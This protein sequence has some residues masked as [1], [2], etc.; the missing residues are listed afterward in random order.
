MGTDEL[1]PRSPYTSTSKID[2]TINSY[3][4]GGVNVGYSNESDVEYGNG[5]WGDYENKDGFISS[6]LGTGYVNVRLKYSANYTNPTDAQPIEVWANINNYN[7]LTIVTNLKDITGEVRLKFTNG[8]TTYWSK[9]TF[10]VEYKNTSI[11]CS[12]PN[13]TNWYNNEWKVEVLKVNNDVIGTNGIGSVSYYT[14]NDATGL[15]GFAKATNEGAKTNLDDAKKTKPRYFYLISDIES[16]GEM[17]PI[18]LSDSEGKSWFDGVFSGAYNEG[19]ESAATPHYI[20]NITIKTDSNS[21]P[22]FGLFG[23]IGGP[24]EVNDLVIDTIKIEGVTQNT[25]VGGL[26]GKADERQPDKGKDEIGKSIKNITVQGNST[27][28]GTTYVGGIIGENKKELNNSRINGT[29]ISSLGTKNDTNNDTYIYVGGIAAKSTANISGCTVENSSTIGEGAVSVTSKTWKKDKYFVGGIVGHTTGTVTS[30]NIS[31]NTSIVGGK[32]NHSGKLDT[33]LETYTGGVIG[34]KNSSQAVDSD[35]NFSVGCTVSGHDNVGGIIGFNAG[36][37]INNV[38]FLG[39]ISSGTGEN[40]GGIVGC[41]TGGTISNCTNTIEIDVKGKNVGGIAGCNYSK[42]VTNCYNKATVKGN[43]NVGGILGISYG[44]W[45]DY[46]GNESNVKGVNNTL[47]GN[48]IDTTDLLLFYNIVGENA[49]GVGGI[50]GKVHNATIS[51]SYNSGTVICNY[52]GGGIAGLNSGGTIKY[53][54][55]KGKI[56]NEGNR[57]TAYFMGMRV[58]MNRMGGICGSGL[59]V[60]INKSYNIGDVIGES[61]AINTPCGSPTGGIIG[62]L[63]DDTSWIGTD[64]YNLNTKYFEIDIGYLKIKSSHSEINYCYNTGTI[65][66]KYTLAVSELSYY[67]GA[68]VGYVGISI[69]LDP[70]AD[71]KNTTFTNNYYLKNSAESG[72]GRNGKKESS[73]DGIIEYKGLNSDELKKQLYI[74]ANNVKD[75][76]DLTNNEYVYSTIAP[77]EE[78]KGY[79]GY[80]ILWWELEGYVRLESYICSSYNSSTGIVYEKIRSGHNTTFKIGEKS[81]VLDDKINIKNFAN[82]R[83]SCDVHSW[84]MMIKKGSYYFE[85]SAKD[86]GNATSSRDID[87]DTKLLALLQT[88]SASKELGVD[89]FS[90]YT[91]NFKTTR[92]VPG[93]RTYKNGNIANV[94]TPGL[95]VDDQYYS[96]DVSYSA[97]VGESRSEDTSKIAKVHLGGGSL[98]KPARGD[99]SYSWRC[100]YVGW[101]YKFPKFVRSTW[102]GDMSKKEDDAIYPKCKI[103]IPIQSLADATVND[104][105]PFNSENCQV[106]RADLS[107]IYSYWMDNNLV[108]K[109]D[110]TGIAGDSLEKFSNLKDTICFDFKYGNLQAYHEDEIKYSWYTTEAR[111]RKDDISEVL[112]L[113]DEISE[114]SKDLEITVSWDAKYVGMYLEITDIKLEVEYSVI[115][116]GSG[117]IIYYDL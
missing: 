47:I 20:K 49:T 26:A 87:K 60:N 105:F 85:A 54:F 50:I 68:I 46:C 80:G 112:N 30:I 18:C 41:N 42:K 13:N 28:K 59:G 108:N 32:I 58:I 24:G 40:I 91:W 66:G 92:N 88:G 55:N 8:T 114:T 44:G 96:I 86:Y 71:V 62:F 9:K 64:T 15:K 98:I 12:I 37:N 36:G 116:D 104:V 38:Q 34:Y 27:I 76:D 100:Q 57:N 78:D 53:C 75:N 89:G 72:G 23:Y 74:F 103:A 65:K 67:N 94:A 115:T 101:K 51:R 110:I 7:N 10:K 90:K 117:T 33:Y 39:K 48:S 82:D 61:S 31:E 3:N 111:A 4:N 93:R 69:N 17:T 83:F 6:E 16:V 77:L 106:T 107:V 52:N 73:T 109:A 14:I 25:Y 11:Y 21:N 102:E 81:Q 29:S 84:I 22:A 97:Q 1:D 5:E 2:V 70:K 113:K 19:L 45:I 63:V 99:L 79:Y 95:Y 43:K 35:S 56:T